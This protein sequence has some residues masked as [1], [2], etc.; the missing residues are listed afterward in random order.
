MG[1]DMIDTNSSCKIGP[2]IGSWTWD[3][4]THRAPIALTLFCCCC[5]RRWL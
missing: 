4:P 1:M 5:R 2:I 3:W